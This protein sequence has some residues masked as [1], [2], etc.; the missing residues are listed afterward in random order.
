MLK[1]LQMLK[2]LKVK[3]FLTLLMIPFP[4]WPLCFGT[5]YPF[6]YGIGRFWTLWS[7]VKACWLGVNKWLNVSKGNGYIKGEGQY[8]HDYIFVT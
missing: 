1:W 5:N 8:I 3:V 2:V 4:I 7:E 6:L